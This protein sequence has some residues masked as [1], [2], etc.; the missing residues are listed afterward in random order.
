MLA[1]LA[2]FA[3]AVRAGG[4]EVFKRGDFTAEQLTFYLNQVDRG[5]RIGMDRGLNKPRYHRDIPPVD[6]DQF[7]QYP[8]IKAQSK[9]L[10]ICFLSQ[11]YP[12]GDFGGIGRF[13]CDLATGLAALGHEIHVITRSPDTHRVDLEDGV[14]MHRLES[15]SRCPNDLAS[16]PIAPNLEVIAGAYH[17]VC[18]I[19]ERGSVDVVS[20]PLWLFEGLLCSLDGRF[21]TVLSLMTSLQTIV[22][23]HPS[24]SDK[25]HVRQMLALEGIAVRQAEFLHA[26]S[27][28]DSR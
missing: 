12:P 25:P 22:T 1:V 28:R 5:M 14:W 26:I 4:E 6:P 16:T 15:G 8:T 7:V 27:E 19:H 11:E 23:M 17:E 2:H 18:R 20:G 13:T 3:A 10:T 21:P 24:W 9:R